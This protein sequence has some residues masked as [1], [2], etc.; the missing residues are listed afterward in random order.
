AGI[1]VISTPNIQQL[2]SLNDVV[3]RIT[4]VIGRETIP[5][6]VVRAADQLEPHRD[7]RARRAVGQPTTTFTKLDAAPA[8]HLRRRQPRRI[9][10]AG[11]TVSHRPGRRRAPHPPH[12]GLGLAT[13]NI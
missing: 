2:E 13:A 6:S 12:R 8:N 7:G 4:T 10:G 5:D 3:A 11:A 9:A 1:A